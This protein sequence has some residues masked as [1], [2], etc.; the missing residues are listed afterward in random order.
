MALSVLPQVSC[1]PRAL[2]SRGSRLRNA[3][4]GQMGDL[5]HWLSRGCCRPGSES[6]PA[7]PASVWLC[8]DLA[9]PCAAGAV[10]ALNPK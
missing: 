7:V 1:S 9:H 10:L 5:Q 3:C 8:W 4:C 6:G 2:Y